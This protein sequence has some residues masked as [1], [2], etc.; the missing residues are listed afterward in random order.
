MKFL[1]GK[2]VKFASAS[3]VTLGLVY[4]GVPAQIATQAGNVASEHVEEL[5]N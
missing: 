4:L 3:L 1:K 2:F 5:V